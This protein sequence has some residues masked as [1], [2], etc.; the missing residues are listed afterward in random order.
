MEAGMREPLKPPSFKV[1]RPDTEVPELWAAGQMEGPPVSSHPVPVSSE[2]DWKD[3]AGKNRRPVRTR[4][5]PCQQA[6]L[7]PA[8]ADM[9]SSAE[10]TFTETI[11]KSITIQ[12][13]PGNPATTFR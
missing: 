3:P 9:T 5:A 13:I 11:I 12:D 8:E 7:R 2:V 6:P 10:F 4:R 1:A